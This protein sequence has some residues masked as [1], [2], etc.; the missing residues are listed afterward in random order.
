M[1]G[2]EGLSPTNI[3]MSTSVY[4]V[5]CLYS[6]VHLFKSSTVSGKICHCTFFGN[7]IGEVDLLIDQHDWSDSLAVQLQMFR[8]SCR[9]KTLV[10][11][12]SIFQR[13]VSESLNLIPAVE[14]LIS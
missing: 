13:M 10:D 7:L 14:Q 12:H 5:T 11:I 9:I 8:A 2:C 3:A 1:W 6:S 4:K